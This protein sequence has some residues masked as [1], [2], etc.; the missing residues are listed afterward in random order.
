MWNV[1]VMPEKCKGSFYTA[2]QI[3]RV[4]VNKLKVYLKTFQEILF[5]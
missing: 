3:I 1:E 2:M 5:F 4:Y